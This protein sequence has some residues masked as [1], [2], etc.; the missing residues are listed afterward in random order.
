MKTIILIL[1]Y[2]VGTLSGYG[3]GIFFLNKIIHELP[4]L[5]SNIFTLI[6]ITLLILIYVGEQETKYIWKKY[7]KEVAPT[8]LPPITASLLLGLWLQA[9]SY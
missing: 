5:I 7:K 9:M 1:T 8:S 4:I 6:A 2:V 3:F